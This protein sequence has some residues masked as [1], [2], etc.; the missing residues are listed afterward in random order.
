VNRVLLRWEAAL[1]SAY[2]LE[3]S[4]NRETWEQVCSTEAGMG[5][6]ETCTSEPTDALCVRLT[7]LERGAQ[8]GYSP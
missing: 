7:G 5:D 8:Y 6:E 3:A 4:T 2:I 1:R